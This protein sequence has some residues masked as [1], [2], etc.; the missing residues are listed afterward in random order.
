[1]EKCVF[2]VAKIA[3]TAGDALKL[4][5]ITAKGKLLAV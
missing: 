3:T 4:L 5:H 2:L 1:M